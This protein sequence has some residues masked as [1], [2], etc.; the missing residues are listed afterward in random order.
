MRRREFTAGVLLTVVTQSARAQQ[1]YLLKVVGCVT[2]GGL[3]FAFILQANS[4]P[5]FVALWVL[6]KY[7]FVG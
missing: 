3:V 1:N 7:R 4:D 5:G 2:A 6:L